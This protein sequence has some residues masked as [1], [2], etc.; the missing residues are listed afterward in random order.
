[1]LDINVLSNDQ[2]KQLMDPVTDAG[3]VSVGVTPV[4][5]LSYNTH[6]RLAAIVNDSALDIYIGFGSALLINTGIRL[7][8]LGGS[9]E[10]GLFTS[11]P[12]LGEIWAV[13]AVAG[14]NLTFVEV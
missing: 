3:S 4:R 7:N 14:S 1:M 5:V 11:F 2:L 10:F 13:S 8:A 9:F 12:W 6:R